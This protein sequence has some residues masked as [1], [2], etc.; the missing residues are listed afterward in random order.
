MLWWGGSTPSHLLTPHTP[1]LVWANGGN[2]G[3]RASFLSQRTLPPG[4]G[5]VGPG[6]GVLKRSLEGLVLG[7]VHSPRPHRGF[8]GLL[9]ISGL[10]QET[11]KGG[12][13]FCRSLP[14]P[15]VVG[16]KNPAC[17]QLTSGVPGFQSYW[18]WSQSSSGFMVNSAV[19][20]PLNTP[21]Q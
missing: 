9:G 4:A 1:V 15:S 10:P 13:Q 16:Q 3:V 19:K 5:R 11:G 20:L 7:G 18:V 6:G 14:H 2:G 12:V 17:W 8:A 21:H